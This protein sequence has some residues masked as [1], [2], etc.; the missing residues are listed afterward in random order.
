MAV[1]RR[2]RER[3][4]VEWCAGRGGAV[5]SVSCFIFTPAHRRLHAHISRFSVLL[6]HA[7]A[8]FLSALPFHSPSFL[9]AEPATY[10]PLISH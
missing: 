7:I 5:R 6:S 9:F 2:R 4:V 8:I 10:A 1:R 3:K